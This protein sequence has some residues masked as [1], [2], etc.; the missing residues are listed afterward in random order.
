MGNDLG[1]GLGS[2]FVFFR[3]QFFPKRNVVFYYAVV[4]DNY[5]PAAVGVGVG[6]FLAR[7][8]VGRPSCVTESR[9]SVYFF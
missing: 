3:L 2:E 7:L 1:V 4:N 6:V 5:P 8:S 9:F